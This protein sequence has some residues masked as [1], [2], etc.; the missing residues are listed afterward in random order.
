MMDSMHL[1][2]PTRS[3][4]NQSPKIRFTEMY[5]FFDSS[6][7]SSLSL[8]SMILGITIVLLLFITSATPDVFHDAYVDLRTEIASFHT[9]QNN[10]SNENVV[11]LG[12]K[13]YH[14]ESL[15]F[16]STCMNLVGEDGTKLVHSSSLSLN[17]ST[18]NGENWKTT[19]NKMDMGSILVLQNSSMSLESIWMKMNENTKSSLSPHRHSSSSGQA[20]HLSTIVGSELSLTSC[21]LTVSS[22]SSGFL[23]GS[24][25]SFGD[26]SSIS[27]R[28]CQILVKDGNMRPLTKIL[29]SGL[30]TS[31]AISVSSLSLDSFKIIS[32]NSLLFDV[33]SSKSGDIRNCEVLSS[34][35]SSS[36]RNL[37]STRTGPLQMPS[38][39]YQQ[40]HGLTI[41]ETVGALQGTIL[42]DH[43]FGGSHLC[44]NTTFSACRSSFP[45][46]TDITDIPGLSRFFVEARKHKLTPFDFVGQT[47]TRH[48]FWSQL[49]P[50]DKKPDQYWYPT[51]YAPITFSDC[52]F[53]DLVDET[54][55]A[56][57]AGGA[58]LHLLTTS[59]LLVN[60][61][62]F[63]NCRT[64]KG[65]GGAILVQ[66][67]EQ[68]PDQVRVE[69]STFK[70]CSSRSS[71]G[72]AVCMRPP[73][74]LEVVSCTFES[75]SALVGTGGSIYAL[76]CA[77]SLSTFK[78]NRAQTGGGLACDNDLTLHF[79]HFEGNRAIFDPDFNGTVPSDHLYPLFGI[80][81]S[82]VHWEAQSDLLFVR[83]DGTENAH[84]TL[85][86]PCS[87]LSTAVSLAPVD[88]SVEVQVGTGS[89]G[90]A[91]VS[92]SQQIT[93]NG[94]FTET[95][96]QTTP[97][98]TSFSIEVKD[99]SSLTIDTFTLSPLVGKP[100]VTIPS[101]ATDPEITMIHLR[102]SGS[103]I[104]AI[105]FDFRAGTV[106]LQ[107]SCFE[108]LSDIQ[109]SLISVAGSTSLTISSCYFI[110]IEIEA[111][112]IDV[113]AGILQVDST[114]FR[115][116]N[117][118]VLPL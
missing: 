96:H 70:N 98:T 114:H 20:H 72:G 65:S 21:G 73:V 10:I 28:R 47:T 113:D 15:V 6:F 26:Q 117:R 64:M 82:D 29:S 41:T 31:I 86:E 46:F 94:F 69:T 89:F 106:T 23:I 52:T 49:K 35:T 57:F 71:L 1:E 102:L 67:R 61:C 13:I 53:T 105:P 5:P 12:N 39:L 22:E 58:A 19:V 87:L 51:P 7:T 111:S 62:V 80:S 34:L 54:E 107:C 25:P 4:R 45:T 55:D 36:F 81:F 40:N 101:G 63:T 9:N 76:S 79:C 93:L 43:N 104:T 90:S 32:G 42:Q 108:S 33:C 24:D 56:K 84:C 100:L 78:D 59:P 75:C 118:H 68:Y 77:V 85:Y 50:E 95:D 60:G 37:T 11:C 27:L 30:S 110:D 103:G 74:R 2:F 16:T 14:T 38:R 109:C 3:R 99:D 116:V 17:P 66:Y 91:I 88:D 112:V 115:H 18:Q 83:S 97:P 48:I 8:D 44:V 92:D